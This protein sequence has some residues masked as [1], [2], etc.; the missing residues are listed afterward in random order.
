LTLTV[1]PAP[2]ASTPL[3]R[4]RR[5]VVLALAP[6]LVLAGLVAVLVA[7]ARKP[8]PASSTDVA[9]GAL[10]GAPAFSA[11]DLRDPS[12][13]VAFDGTPDRATV[14]NFFAAWCVPCRDELPLFAD[15]AAS[16]TTVDVVGIDV[17][18]IR[19]DALT[20]L[21]QSNAT[22]PVVADPYRDLVRQYRLRGMPA[23]VFVAPGGRV[24][25]THQGPLNAGQLRRLLDQLE[26]A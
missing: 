9:A 7:S 11:P 5:T 18:D 15:A 25:A 21:A 16:R 23:T 22:F 12:K 2:V 13:T 26:A 20:L 24:V 19:T 8:A 6:V 10:T 14:I 4:P 17:Q 1:A 3:S